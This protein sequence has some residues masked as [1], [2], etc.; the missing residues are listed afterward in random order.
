MSRTLIILFSLSLI[1]CIPVTAQSNYGN[2]DSNNIYS[3]YAK[4]VEFLLETRGASST[5]IRGMIDIIR[6]KKINSD[7]SL[8]DLLGKLYSS[9]RGIGIIFYFFNG[10]SLRRVF[11]EPGMVKEKK[12]F[13]ISKDE[14]L[15]LSTDLNHTLGLYS[16]ADN[17]SPKLRGITPKAPAKSKGVTYDGVVKKLTELLLPPSFD[18]SYKHLL[19]IPALN[20]GTIPFHLLRPYGDNTPLIDLCSFT[21][22]PGLIDLFTLR[23]KVLKAGTHWMGGDMTKNF[24]ENYNINRLDKISFSLNNPLFISNPAYPTNTDFDFP[25]LPGAKKEIDSAI[26]YAKKYKLLAGKQA[27]KDSVVEYMKKANMVY[28]ATHGIADAEKPMEKSFLVLSGADPF[29]TAKNIMD[30]RNKNP[31]EKTFPEMAIL[32]ACQ[33]GLGKSMEA[34]VAGL[35]RSFLLGGSNH[36]IMS[37]WNVSDESTAY[38]MSRFIFHLQTPHRFMPAEPLRLAILDTKKKFPHPSQWASFSLFGIDY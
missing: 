1:N 28:F 26:H 17:R 5:D 11:F 38:L 12:T 7:E 4:Q 37:L 8:A 32:S 25:D 13:L 19:I 18:T 24:D 9:S 21:V 36:V 30:L 33:T 23:I 35:A 29:L 34:G 22:I 15:Q 10:D 2:T 16:L 3:I 27:I 20:I 31:Y 14:I 6:D